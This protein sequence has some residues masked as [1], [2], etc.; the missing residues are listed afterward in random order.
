M[1]L[2][3]NN[4]SI[5]HRIGAA[6]ALP[7]IGLLLVS[8]W[9]IHGYYQT[10][11]D[12]NNLRRIAELA[13]ALS[14]LVHH[15]QLERGLSTGLVSA[16]TERDID[17]FS[18]R[19]MAR[20]SE[21]DRQRQSLTVALSAFREVP[22]DFP[23]L[24][25]LRPRMV[26]AQARLD[27]LETTRAAV[28]AR[29]LSSAD[30][31]GYFNDTI[32]DFIGIAE[33]LMRADT[34]DELGRSISAYTR[35][36]QLKE[37]VGMER[38][39]GSSGFASGRFDRKSHTRLIELIDRQHHYQREFEFYAT[40][41]QND[42]FTQAMYGVN[43]AE[44]IRM[45]RIALRSIESGNAEGITA[46][47][48][49]DHFT[50]KIDRLK[51]VEDR[52]GIDLVAT[53]QRIE[54]QA[55][56]TVQ[57][58]SALVMLVMLLT[59]LLTA[60]IARG[61]IF[62]LREMTAA[63]NRLADGD[64]AA[65][66]SGSDGKDEIG[67]LAR[68]AMVFRNHQFKVAEAEEQIRIAAALRLH[69]QAL[70]TISQGVLITDIQRRPI[71]ANLAFDT[72]F[73]LSG[74]EFPDEKHLPLSEHSGD[75]ECLKGLA[76]AFA[77]G[78]HFRDALEFRCHDGKVFWVDVTVT[79]V[80]D[81]T[82]RPTHLVGVM[83]D[84][85]DSRRVEQELRIAAT[86]FESLH[87]MMVTDAK[88]TILRV[89]KAFVD[90]TGYSAD[91][92]VGQTPSILKSGRHDADFY[93]NM[94]RELAITGAWTGEIWDRRKNGE[95]Y[96]KWQTVSAVRNSEGK[97]SHY[98]AAFS[99]ISERK[100]AEQRI[101]DLAFY[102]PLT[103]LP[104]RRL[105]LDR[106]HQALLGSARSGQ[107]GALLFID[108]DNF[109][110][111][112]D[113]R[114]HDMGDLLLIEVAD[115]LTT[116]LRGCDTAARLGG[117]EFVVMLES[118]GEDQSQ[119]AADAEVVGEKIL[120]ILNRNYD[121]AGKSHHSTP[122]IGVTLFH[123]ED[124]TIDELLKQADMAM[125]QSKAA[126]RNAMRFFD[127]AMQAIVT[128]R[129]ILESDLRQAI[130]EEQFVLFYQSQVDGNGLVT[131]A[132]ALVRWRHPTRGMVMP[133][134]FI[135]AAEETGLIVPLGL[136]VLRAACQ[137][138]TEWSQRAE[139]ADLTIAVNVSARQLRH[140]EFIEKFLDV[141]KTTGANPHRL[142]LELT[143]SVLLD[144]VENTIVTMDTLKARGIS[145]SLDDFG[146]GYSSLA[147]LKRLPLDQ[148]KIDRSF[149]QDILS[150]ANDA[151]IA[152]AIVA[153]GQSLGLSVIAE[154]VETQGQRDFL[155]DHNCEAFQ[156]YLFGKPEE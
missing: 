1:Q 2:R 56:T 133:S 54:T 11:R 44:I 4:I 115:R 78:Q 76:P 33:E 39:L 32:A 141:L 92:A 118:L 87:G 20:Q 55:T 80:L 13:P 23:V 10:A 63:M 109:K 134:E 113:T 60:A 72:I 59:L 47:Q 12:A 74:S 65:E 8:A 57:R 42:Y 26:A 58:I 9:L 112:N 150:D 71:Y 126:G 6:L 105:L 38:A 149:V 124:I 120:E 70:S 142:K 21:T 137:R 136:W 139:T 103:A 28:L 53:T 98:V 96:P 52:I 94:W 122:S 129:S 61:I 84:I 91:E 90:M 24:E 66:I 49:F 108:L 19:L 144:D 145:F 40:S 17:T 93:A 29:T 152:K 62:P 156:G 48:W 110:N 69:H 155:A 130:D 46:T 82:D 7:I 27:Q 127:P 147:Y 14:A 86:A 50:H 34:H 100:A 73:G 128:N 75:T 107:H 111:L 88:G 64:R 135:P 121:L 43:E 132:E 119:A 114:G 140:P 51:M 154:G 35:L 5:G 45:R 41:E 25:Q 67:D 138:L 30:T 102:D 95:I 15:L 79:P 106:L 22:A 36:M 99:D 153:L 148:L 104:N 37:H 85:T 117:D 3:L 151:V 131:G 16:R 18:R 81:A 83:R 101:H 31:S 125:Y 68:A 146:T 89:N 77:S 143:E 123:G 116:C 97:I